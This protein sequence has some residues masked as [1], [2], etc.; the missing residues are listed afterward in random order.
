MI[1]GKVERAK[2]AM[3]LE[4]EH[5][6]EL[7]SSIAMT[8]RIV[9]FLVCITVALVFFFFAKSILSPIKTCLQFARTMSLGDLSTRMKMGTENELAELCTALDVM[10]DS[11]EAKAKVAEKIAEGDITEDIVMASDRDTLGGSLQIMIDKLNDLL[12]KINSSAG[13][14]SGGASELASSSETLSQGASEQSSSLE[15]ISSSM[16]EAGTQTTT[17]AENATQANQISVSARNA[18]EGGSKQMAEMVEAMTEINDSS[19]MIVKI[20]KVIDD[21]A[22]QTNLLALNAAVEAARA[23]VHGKGFAVVAEEVR[24]L[25]GRSAKAAK[26]TADLIEDSTQKVTRGTD[27]A[28]RTSESLTEITEKVTKIADLVNKIA[29]SS[30]EQTSSIEEIS[31]GL[32]QID[33]VTQS[34]AAS[35]EET[36]SASEE[37]SS[38][39]N[40]L[41]DLVSQF[42]LRQDG[43]AVNLRA[44]AQALPAPVEKV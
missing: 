43:R 39:A 20:I 22:F 28:T 31:L 25:A 13:Q 26:E 15:E 32:D 3:E 33:K 6:H 21:I 14:V 37:L 44:L 17:N 34:N 29:A 7:M 30:K 41:Q 4:V 11:I 19:Q 24:S 16:I 9:S 8:I 40:E 1:G 12:S 23:G 5:H 42:S 2:E 27:I 10:A 35:A 36:A 38:Q 18:A